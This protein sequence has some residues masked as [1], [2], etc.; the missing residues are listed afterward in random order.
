M[1][2]RV[3]PHQIVSFPSTGQEIG[4]VQGCAIDLEALDVKEVSLP[5]CF[6]SQLSTCC[7]LF[8]TSY[9]LV[10]APEARP[11]SGS[12]VYDAHSSYFQ[13]ARRL[14][15]LSHNATLLALSVLDLLR[16]LL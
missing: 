7:R 1:S 8:V 12:E 16:H 11:S 3:A 6:F 13:A 4:R 9:L 5:L 14:M 2:A 10:D 15:Q